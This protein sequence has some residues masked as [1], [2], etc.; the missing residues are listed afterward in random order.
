MHNTAKRQLRSESQRRRTKRRRTTTWSS[1]SASHEA[2]EEQTV[3]M[4]PMGQMPS[5]GGLSQSLK[6]IS[7]TLLLNRP[8]ASGLSQAGPRFRIRASCEVPYSLA[9]WEAP[10]LST[11]LYLHVTV[12]SGRRVHQTLSRYLEAPCL[13]EAMFNPA[14][15]CE[16][17]FHDRLLDTYQCCEVRHSQDWTYLSDKADRCTASFHFDGSSSAHQRDM[18]MARLRQ[19]G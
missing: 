16:R 17:S 12:N 1:F 15:R 18:L 13:Q 8:Y 3:K 19:M 5:P 2:M 6:G 14:D 9:I 4:T 11:S 10:T 7:M